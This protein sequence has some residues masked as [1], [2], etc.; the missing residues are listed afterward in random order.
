M[1]SRMRSAPELEAYQNPAEPRVKH[2][3][4]LLVGE[5]FGLDEAAQTPFLA[6]VFLLGGNL[7]HE[8]D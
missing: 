3:R 5:Q 4:R 2:G 1:L 7:A 8:I 6:A